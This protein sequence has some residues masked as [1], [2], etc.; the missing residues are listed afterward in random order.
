M[1]ASY[2]DSGGLGRVRSNGGEMKIWRRIRLDL[3]R[4]GEDG[5]KSV[6]AL[7]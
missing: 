7:N 6:K 5:D 3:L 2:V 1:G 4:S